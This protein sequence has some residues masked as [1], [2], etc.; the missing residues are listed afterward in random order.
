MAVRVGKRLLLSQILFIAM[1][2]T[3]LAAR[4]TPRILRH[5]VPIVAWALASIALGVL[6][7]LAAVI[8]PPMGAFGIVA[9]A[10]LVLLWVMPDL[11]LVSPGLVRKA[12]F[13]MVVADLCIPFYYTVQFGGLP[14]ISARRLAT[15]ALIVP[16]MTAMAASSDARRVVIE[17]IRSSGLIFICAVGYLVMATLSVGTSPLPSESGSALIE[18][19]LSWYVPFFAMIYIPRDNDDV[20]FILKIICICA[21][22]NTAAGIVEFIV[23]RNVFIDI[24]PK[25]MLDALIDN[26]PTLQELLPDNPRH[27]R[28]GLY[29]AAS[30]FVTPLSFGELEIIVI[31][32]AL[33]FALHRKN[34]LERSFGWIVV[35]GGLVGIFS[36][37][38]RGGYVGVLLSVA[39]FVSMWAVRKGINNRARA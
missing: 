18:A 34:L 19:I 7:G 13:V 16:F 1:A 39:V 4:A 5:A 27:F 20:I 14:W 6:V 26:N 28:N 25:S 23:H 8:L 35:L 22:F 29:R 37:G 33:F 21:L 30:T 2:E 31:P 32:I 9:V 36:S 12:F 17:R 3:K 24:F 11:P 10:A 15:F 38:S